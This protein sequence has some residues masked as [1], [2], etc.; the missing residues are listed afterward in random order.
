[1]RGD[2][3]AWL[4]TA[5][6]AVLGALRFPRGWVMLG[7]AGGGGLLAVVWAWRRFARDDLRERLATTFMA[8]FG[9][10]LAA[11]WIGGVVDRGGLAAATL[12]ALTGTLLFGRARWRL[13]GQPVPEAGEARGRV[14]FE[15]TVHALGTPARLPGADRAVVMWA[16]RQGWRRW[17]SSERFEVRTG[18]RRVRVAPTAA[19]LRLT[20]RTWV[21]RGA[22]GRAAARSLAGH[23]DVG[24]TVR[25]RHMN[26]GDLVHVVGVAQLSD[27]PAAPTYRDPA[28]ISL[29][30][31]AVVLGRGSLA[32]ARRRALLGT[33]AWAALALAAGALAVWRVTS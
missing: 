5:G 16:A 32:A 17:S 4:V 3:L 10:C 28:R 18:T 20:G 22:I 7:L 21:M 15:G 2:V 29:F 6:L 30:S 13:R 23:A 31:R 27:D 26:E 33:L 24:P 11:G 9:A 12:L 8:W 14:W 19:Q 1:M 25:M